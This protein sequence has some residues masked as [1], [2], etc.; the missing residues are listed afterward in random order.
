MRFSLWGL[1]ST[2]ASFPEALN[3]HLLAFNER[4]IVTMVKDNQQ[5]Q[6]PSQ[7]GLV[8]ND[9]KPWAM[10][11]AAV[12][13]DL[14]SDETAGLSQEEARRRLT[15]L[16]P[17]EIPEPA[18]DPLWRRYI[19]QLTGD[20]VVKLLLV[21]SAVSLLLHDYLEGFAIFLMLN[22]M[23][24]FGLWQEGKA[25]DAAKSLRKLDNPLKFVFR[26]GKRLEVAIGEIVPGDLVYLPTGA[27]SPADGR[28]CA[29]VNAEK[30]TSK[31][32]GESLSVAVETKPLNPEIVIN[33]QTNMI[34]RG[35]V[36]L[37]GNVTFVVT[38]TG[39]QTEIGKIATQ[40]AASDQN[41][42]PL[43]EQLDQL[44]DNLTKIFI[45]IAT[46][47]IGL[48]LLR[49]FFTTPDQVTF[50]ELKEAF[51]SAVALIIAA[52]PEGLPAVMTITL[53]IA[54]GMMVKKNALIRRP[55]AVEGGGSMNVLLTDKTGTLTANKMEVT[56]LFLNGKIIE[57]GAVDSFASHQ[58]AIER[59]A[60]VARLCNNSSSA[61]E[62][63][64]TEWVQKLELAWLDETE[65]PRVLEHEFNQ[66]LKRMTTIHTRLESEYIVLTKGAPE[67]IIDLC[68]KIHSQNE[69]V[70]LTEQ[71]KQ[72]IQAAI[73]SLAS[74][75][76]RVLA[77]A[78]RVL[79][80]NPNNIA[81][82]AAETN[83][84]FVGLVGIMDPPRDD[85]KPAVVKLATA[86]IRT[87]M[88]TGDNPLT[89]YQIARM[90]GIIP[91]DLPFEAA[92][93]TGEDL[94]ELEN[95]PPAL[96]ERLHKVRVF[97]RVTPE[98]KA[99]I[100]KVMRKAGFIVGMTGDGVND[101]IAIKE[102]DIGFA[103]GNG[104]D[105]ARETSD[106]VL[107]DS[108]FGTIPIAV[109]E[110]RNVL[111]R[112]R[113]Y[114]SY[115]LSGNGCQVGAFIVAYVIGIPIPL[116]AL[117]LLVINFATDSFPALAM[118]FEPGEE[119]VMTKLPRKREDP[120]I[121]KTMWIHIAVQTVVATIAIMGVYYYLLEILKE[122]LA[123]ARSAAF[124]T[125]ISQKLLRA[126][127]ARSQTHNIWEIGLLQNKYTLGAVA[128]SLAIALFFVYVPV[129]NEA[130]NIT[131]LPLKFLGLAAIAGL[132]PPIAEEITKLFLRRGQ[133]G[134]G[135]AS[136]SLEAA[137]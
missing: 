27:I 117:V 49:E 34:H 64:L 56:H 19:A 70:P 111:Y 63:A 62:T 101:A 16:G 124:M 44:G 14:K 4:I 98:H 126:F 50:L 36:V 89:A 86:G 20:A 92:V 18:A 73:A 97:A 68:D 15:E 47:V 23:A 37:S 130:I 28:V 129:V 58:N 102:S 106:V 52:I 1:A 121:T 6:S 42:T 93:I 78:E 72:A 108:R 38:K 46:L 17:N 43:D 2:S 45:W 104:T 107:M 57:V 87:V 74:Q 3:F 120:F 10:P 112:I 115:I 90:V 40:L 41:R 84:T 76:L 31:L 8:A 22:I 26:D 113:L 71:H 69:A 81:R 128:I 51:I 118:S 24:G 85:V 99:Q 83:L 123:V 21:G 33:E 88:V 59:A 114:L 54:T 82:S 103:M 132:F 80:E 125:Y 135:G 48:G 7:A 9:F 100:V 122:D 12:L 11:V 75:G 131:T 109:E 77:L 13:Q 95:P 91:Q 5:A 32:T 25:T 61:T 94:T 65:L 137:I 116:T 110:G 53:A 136:R 119:D 127:T 105:V 30:D 55:K 134:S 79:H 60:R 35:D 67:R 29:A 66:T 133:A 96:L 39:S